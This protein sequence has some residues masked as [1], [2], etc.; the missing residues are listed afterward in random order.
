MAD[1]K[2][3]RKPFTIIH[4]ITSNEESSGCVRLIVPSM[5]SGT[6]LAYDYWTRTS[7]GVRRVTAYTSNYIRPSGV[8]AIVGTFA[9][10]DKLTASCQFIR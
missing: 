6:D 7:G 9:A 10:N 4:S 5:P 3:Y 8:L 1:V 2:T